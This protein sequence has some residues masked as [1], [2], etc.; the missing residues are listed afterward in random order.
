MKVWLCSTKCTL[1]Y[2]KL[3]IPTTDLNRILKYQQSQD[4]TN[5]FCS[6]LMQQY[7]L[8]D[9]HRERKNYNISRTKYGKPYYIDNPNI[10]FNISHDNYMIMGAILE[11][12][13]VIGCDIMM[14]TGRRSEVSCFE[15]NFTVNE[16]KY[17]LDKDHLSYRRFLELWCLKEAYI[18]A[19][20]RGLIIP[21]DDI[22]FSINSGKAKM[23][24]PAGYNCMLYN[25]ERWVGA[26]VWKSDASE[27][28]V[29][30]KWLEIENIK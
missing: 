20:G 11:S 19:D 17:I 4:Q 21:L 26:I 27:E 6:V 5:A 18:K 7:M 12:S 10:G 9:H 23:I 25:E 30:P 13:G 8:R 3:Q 15:S 29:I 22:E 28:T 14:L 16:W 24:Y 1:D 2:N